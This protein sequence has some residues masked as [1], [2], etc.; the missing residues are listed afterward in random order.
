MADTKISRP[1]RADQ[2]GSYLRPDEL[3]QA[4]Q[5]RAD[6]KITDKQLHDIE[7]KFI[8]DLVKTQEDLG[9]PVVTDGEFRR[10][11]WN[12]DFLGGFDNVVE[13]PGNLKLYHRL[14]D[15]TN[16]TNQISGWAVT[17]KFKRSKPIQV[18][19]FNF[20]KSI[21]KV[22]P[23]TCITSPTLL[24]FRGGREAIDKKTY[25]KIEQF[26]DDVAAAYREEIKDLYAAGCRYVQL[27]DTNFAY[28]CDERFRN[29]VKEMGED[30]TKLT[31]TYIK[32]VND[33]LRDKPKDMLSAIHLCRG[34]SSTAGAA[35]GGYDVVGPQLFPQLDVDAFFLEYDDAR[36]GGF[37]ALKDIPKGKSVVLGLITTKRADLEKKDDLKRRIDEA[38]KVVP[39]ENLCLSPQCGFA[40]GASMRKRISIDD[41]MAKVK[42]LVETA[43]DVWGGQM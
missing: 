20:L 1:Y 8:R 17:G 16:S 34:N 38:A 39:M 31:D 9:M 13:Q 29:A 15:G 43:R 11:S 5:D 4:R 23:K 35:Q 2:V 42:L 28:L 36:A 25:P 33:S 26:F 30:P 10:Q 41:E 27:D 19:G 21:T 32:L 37:D 12:K 14:P 7:D 6:N 24:H 40:S 22:T 3:M 18:D